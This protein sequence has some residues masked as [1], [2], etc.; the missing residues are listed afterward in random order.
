MERVP[1][2][3]VAV[4]PVP[5]GKAEYHLRLLLA[6]LID[7]WVSGLFFLR[8]M[9]RATSHDL[10]VHDVAVN[11]IPTTTLWPASALPTA[12]LRGGLSASAAT[13]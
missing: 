2:G 13:G 5:G 3:A 12:R 11:G 8:C 1:L 4:G 6:L 10:V 9:E 7:A